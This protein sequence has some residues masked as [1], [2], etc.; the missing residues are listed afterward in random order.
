MSYKVRNAER[1][2]AHLADTP[3]WQ[4]Q[5][6]TERGPCLRNDYQHGPFSTVG[7]LQAFCEVNNMQ[8]DYASEY[9]EQGYSHAEK[10]VLFANWN[11][12][13]KKLQ[14]RLESQGFA[15]EWSDEWYVDSNRSKAYRTS[16]D[17]HGWESQLLMIDGDYLT[18]DDDLEEWVQ[19]CEDNPNAALPAW[20]DES[21]IAARKTFLFQLGRSGDAYTLAFHVWVKTEDEA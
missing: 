9:G 21:E 16:P 17:S 14:T 10:G 8:C 13:P 7:A 4:I 12:I 11:E 1:A 6:D 15:L 19:Q 18:P 20:W 3:R 5:R 2:K